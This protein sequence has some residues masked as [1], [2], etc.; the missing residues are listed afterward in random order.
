[1]LLTVTVVSS[2]EVVSGLLA[3]TSPGGAELEGVEEV[4]GLL[5]VGSGGENLVD[6]VF[7]ADN[8]ALSERTLDDAVV[9]QGNP[10]LVDLA[11]T[12]LVDELLHRLQVG[13]SKTTRA[14]KKVNWSGRIRKKCPKNSHP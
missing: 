14:N 9:G 4:V 8:A 12:P 3:E 5:E 1:M 7:R 11:E 2:L 13:V 6:E 10:L